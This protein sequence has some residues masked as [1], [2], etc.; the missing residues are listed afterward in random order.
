[1]RVPGVAAV[2]GGVT[3]GAVQALQAGAQSVATAVD[4]MQ[5]LTG[6]VLD[7]V[8]QSTSRLLGSRGS[9][10][11]N[12]DSAS[13]T[14]RWQSGRRGHMELDPLLPL[15]R[16]R[17]QGSVVEEPVRLIPGVSSAHVEGALGRLVVQIDDSLESD[18]SDAVLEEVRSVVNAA[19]AELISA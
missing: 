14:V 19:A 9:T 18:D 10:N 13:A 5:T 15:P 11:G 8:N 4:T 17:E 3:G 16:C 6:P 1:M 2:V 7:T 12:R